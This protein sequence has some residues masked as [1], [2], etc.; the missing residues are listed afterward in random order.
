MPSE[1][2]NPIALLRAQ[3]RLQ[4]VDALIVPR[5]DAHQGEDVAPCDARLAWLTGFSGSAGFAIVTPETVEMFVDGRYT[6]QAA[7]EC[8]GAEFRFH[9]L[10][11]DAPDRWLAAANPA[12]N[13]GYD[14]M[15]LPPSWAERFRAGLDDRLRA[16]DGN[17]VDAVWHDRPA[18]PNAPIRPFPLQ[19]AGR[20]PLE[21]RA[22]LMRALAEAGADLLIETQPDNIGWFLNLRGGDFAHVPA[23]RSF[24][25]IR[26]DGHGKLFVDPCQMTDE[27]VDVLPRWISVRPI[28]SF[29]AEAEAQVSAEQTVLL[30]PD[31]TP[32]A[33]VRLVDQAQ[34]RQLRRISPLTMAKAIKNPVERAGTR[35]C[36][37][38]DGVALT[39][40]CAQIEQMLPTTEL[41][42]EDLILSLRRR[43]DGFLMTSFRTISAA[44][45]NAAMCHYAASPDSNAPIRGGTTYLLDSGGQYESGTT[46]ATRCLAFGPV[47]PAYRKAYTAV[48]KAFHALMTLRFPEGTKG[49][50]IDAI[51]RRPLWDLGMD[52]DHGTGHGVGHS[53]SVHERPLRIGKEVN[54]VNIAAGM[55][56]TVEPG[57]YVAGEYGIR[58]ENQ[59]EVVQC[60]DGFL[61]FSNLTLVPIQHDM[62]DLGSLSPDQIGWL[63]DYNQT[64]RATLGPLLS[65][66]A[67][68]WVERNAAILPT[69]HRLTP[70]R[71]ELTKV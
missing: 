50:H 49:H 28:G 14:A 25:V 31:F 30:D 55:I 46:D 10:V 38:H 8:Q 59:V 66:A 62:L 2:L 39:E 15:L 45:A 17:A 16:M 51:C 67:L 65:P 23:A 18:P 52:Y 29:L 12:W 54:D 6:V 71:Q 4:G 64:I 47:S 24:L 13:V 1:C 41:A 53:L 35:A 21:K 40:F 11:Q 57:H 19:L 61:E 60:P 7:Q 43:N 68:A 27:L 58:I 33:V 44:G 32:D 5:F 3:M 22:D 26:D 70:L 34:A 69:P 36:H 42:A 20:S 63:I 37:L 9:H 48:F 56:L